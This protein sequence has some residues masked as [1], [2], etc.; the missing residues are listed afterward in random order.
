MKL[1]L[2]YNTCKNN[3]SEFLFSL[4]VSLSV[5]LLLARSL[6]MYNSELQDGFDSGR[7]CSRLSQTTRRGTMQFSQRMNERLDRVTKTS[8]EIDKSKFSLIC[9]S[10]RLRPRPSLRLRRELPN[11]KHRFTACSSK[12]AGKRGLGVEL[13]LNDTVCEHRIQMTRFVNTDRACARA[14]TGRHTTARTA[15]SKCSQL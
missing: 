3:V 7:A 14:E 1:N 12:G 15:K 4:S 13:P 9:L 2:N 10:V 6:S 8:T 11:C 5:S